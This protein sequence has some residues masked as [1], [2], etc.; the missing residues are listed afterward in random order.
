MDDSVDGRFSDNQGHRRF[1]CRYSS[2]PPLSA[3]ST[4]APLKSVVIILLFGLPTVPNVAAPVASPPRISARFG[5]SLN[6]P[7]PRL[8]KPALQCGADMF[9]PACNLRSAP[10]KSTGLC[11]DAVFGQSEPGTEFLLLVRVRLCRLIFGQSDADG[12]GFIRCAIAQFE[13]YV[14]Q[15][16]GRVWR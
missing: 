2:R 11:H 8:S 3:S 13:H 6:S 16:V 4:T 9:D 15:H 5:Y 7:E 14:C 12:Q 1:L 10:T